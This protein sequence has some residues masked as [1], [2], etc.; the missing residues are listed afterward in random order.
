M[1]YVSV[2]SYIDDYVVMI[3]FICLPCFTY[4]LYG[5]R[6]VHSVSPQTEKFLQV[7]ESIY[8][9]SFHHN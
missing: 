7:V 2:P 4:I 3:L 5:L 9:L 1:G 8:I 6:I